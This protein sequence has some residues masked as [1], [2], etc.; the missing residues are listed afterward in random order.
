MGAVSKPYDQSHCGSCW[1]FT[2]AA[3]LES[4]SVIS[5]KFKDPPSFSMQQLLDCDASN[6]G[7][8]G[9]W[10]YKAYVYTSQHGIMNF[11][12]YPYRMAANHSNCQYNRNKTVF[13]NI[14]MKQEKSMSN[15]ALMKVLMRQPVGVGILTN[16]NFQFYRSGVMT[17]DTLK[18][19]SG[20]RKVNHGVTV[21]GYG[22]TTLP[23]EKKHCEKYWIVRNSWGT[24]WGENGFFRLCMD[25]TGSKDQP[26]GI[27]Q[28]NRFPTYPTMEET[29]VEAEILFSE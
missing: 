16:A 7:C 10:M 29:G 21:V 15:E 27:C 26:Y 14:G 3:T 13:K 20:D 5:G 24:K 28:L 1:S 11:T 17:E 25:G 8:Q 18:C 2:T 6:S 22:Q 19:S 23:E 4:L 9:G 12:D